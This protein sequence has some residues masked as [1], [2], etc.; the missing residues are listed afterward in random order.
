MSMSRC[1][2]DEFCPVVAGLRHELRR[3]GVRVYA[4]SVAFTGHMAWRDGV[5]PLVRLELRG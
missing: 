5:G 1:T 3:H 2:Y 4:T